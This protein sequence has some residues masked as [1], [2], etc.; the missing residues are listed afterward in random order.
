MWFLS[1]GGKKYFKKKFSF[2]FRHFSIFVRN[3]VTFLAVFEH[4]FLLFF[5]FLFR[6]FHLNNFFKS[7]SFFSL[8]YMGEF[9]LCVQNSWERD[10]RIKNEILQRKSQMNW[11]FLI[12]MLSKYLRRKFLEWILTYRKMFFLSICI[13]LDLNG[14]T[15]IWLID[16]T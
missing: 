5:L 4:F 16:V 7:D 6:I 10:E 3:L 15:L 12:E 8:S 14:A 9:Y 2:L 13:G 11:E 1:D